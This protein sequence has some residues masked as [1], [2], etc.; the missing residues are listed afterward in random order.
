MTLAVP[1]AELLEVFEVD[2][3][4]GTH[5][6]GR[7]SVWEQFKTAPP[8]PSIPQG[9]IGSPEQVRRTHPT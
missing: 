6:P 4:A 9:G 7:L 1:G 3:G 8:F 2:D 5:L